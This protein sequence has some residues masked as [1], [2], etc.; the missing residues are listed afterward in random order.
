[1]SFGWP[2][3]PQIHKGD[4]RKQLEVIADELLEVHAALE[5]G[6]TA[7]ALAE[8]GDV[9]QAL[10]NLRRMLTHRHGLQAIRKARVTVID[11]CRARGYYREG[12][13]GHRSVLFRAGVK[14]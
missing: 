11:R 4:P 6:D 3:I 7:A 5:E 12:T 8:F 13:D 10:A 14:L 9:E 2:E 1:M